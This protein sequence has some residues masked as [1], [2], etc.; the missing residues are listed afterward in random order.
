MGV[1]AD[2]RGDGFTFRRALDDVDASGRV[3]H[4]TH[5]QVSVALAFFSE[6]VSDRA[7]AF[8][9]GQA[10]PAP[11][12]ILQGLGRLGLSGGRLV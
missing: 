7:V 8:G 6:H 2:Y 10:L 4:I 12:P 11:P 5:G 1:C 3:E 9:R